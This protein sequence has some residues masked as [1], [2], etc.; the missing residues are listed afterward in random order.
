MQVAI[1]EAGQDNFDFAPSVQP[2]M[3]LSHLAPTSTTAN[4]YVSK[5][6]DSVA[7][8]SC[9][10]PVGGILGGGSSI[11]YMMYTRASASD[12]DDWDQE[13][14]AFED[15]LPL[16]R[17][18]ETDH[19]TS[20][21]DPQLHGSTG[22]LEV[23]Y[24]G[25]QSEIG[26]QFVAATKSCCDVPF[27]DDI[28]DFKTGHG[29]TN[30]A[31]WISPKTGRRQDAAHGYVHPV[32]ET[33][34]NLHLLTELKTIRVVLENGHAT[35]VE[36]CLNPFAKAA[37]NAEQPETVGTIHTMKARQL[38]VVCAGAFGTPMVLERSG[39]GAKDVLEKAGVDVVVDLPGVGAE[40]Q[41]HQLTLAAYQV[42]DEEDTLDDY[43]RGIPEVHAKVGEQWAKEGKGIVASNFIDAGMKWRPTE[44]ELVEM[45]SPAFQ[46]LWEECFENAPDKPMMFGGRCKFIPRN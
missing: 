36:Y 40:Y 29:L 45:G 23:S 15:L 34:T 27:K 35:G 8:R 9:V 4:F 42:D 37:P 2:A 26:K 28:Q 25:H 19:L 39:I 16:A 46:K 43:L 30:W 6:S 5:E 14:W 31:K 1:I 18:M 10:V 22:P 21:Q 20:G 7:G 12:F 41:D 3:Y 17:K 44:A 11:N 32:L 13:G 33:Q 24:G 38:V